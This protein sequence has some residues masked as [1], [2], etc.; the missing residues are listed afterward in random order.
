MSQVGWA[1]VRVGVG[2][3][4]CLS[5]LSQFLLSIS[6]LTAGSEQPHGPGQ[7][8]PSDISSTK[9]L[10]GPAAQTPARLLPLDTDAVF[11][12]CQLEDGQAARFCVQ[13]HEL[14]VVLW[15][16]GQWAVPSHRGP[17]PP[18]PPRPESRRSG[19]RTGSRG[20]AAGWCWWGDGQNLWWVLET[21][22]DKMT[23]VLMQWETA[24]GRPDEAE[25][26][27]DAPSPGERR[28]TVQKKVSNSVTLR[29]LNTIM[30]PSPSQQH[31]KPPQSLLSVNP[32]ICCSVPKSCFCSPLDCRTSG[33]PVPCYRWIHF[34]CFWT[35]YKIY[36][37]THTPACV[38]VFSH[39]LCCV[40]R[41]LYVCPVVISGMEKIIQGKRLGALGSS[42]R[43]FIVFLILFKF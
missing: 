31:L 25:G 36:H 29:K 10:L 5:G 16:G 15:G 18:D 24:S 41:K 13:G 17:H 39:H 22:R 27:Q 2:G 6:Q 23:C 8:L 43:Y 37:V 12:D 38:A 11:H 26:P 42:Y 34:L 19:M 20:R 4:C 33:F 7:R 9:S 30:L 1:L 32:S 40:L 3:P 14:H 21:G 28:L 35:L